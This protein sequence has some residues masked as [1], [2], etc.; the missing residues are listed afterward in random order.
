MMQARDARLRLT[1]LAVVGSALL[2]LPLPSAAGIVPGDANCDGEIDADDVTAVVAAIFEGTSCPGADANEDG[3]TTAADLTAVIR[4]F[5]N[6]A[7]TPTPTR[8]PT[9]AAGDADCN[10]RIDTADLDAAAAAVFEGTTCAGADANGDG[11]F[12]A[13]D[14]TTIAALLPDPAPTPTSTVAKTAT[15]TPQPPGT[16]TA[17]S[18][19]TQT[20]IMTPGVPSPTS[21]RTPLPS[22][23]PE[24][25]LPR[26]FTPTWTI[27][28]TRTRTP[29]GVSTG[30]RTPL[31]TATPTNT[32][33]VSPAR[34]AT[35]TPS[36]AATP[37]PTPSRTSPAGTATVTATPTQTGTPTPTFEG[38][39]PLLRFLGLV[40]ANG[41]VVCDDPQ[42]VCGTTPSPTPFFD[43]GG[44][45]IYEVGIDSGFLLVVEAQP[46]A[47]GEPVGDF[48]PPPIPGWPQRPDLQIQS[49]R[50]LGDGSTAICDVE[51][52]SDGG[53]PGIDPPNFDPA[54]GV[55]DALTDFACRFEALSP[56]NPCTLNSNGSPATV[57]PSLPVNSKQ[58]CYIVAT[59]ASFPPG[60][61]ILSV[62][63]RDEAG[64]VGNIGQIVVRVLP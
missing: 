11:L 56:G 54:A 35:R 43:D 14:L 64:N 36:V 21:T 3:R 39:G 33:V 10:G 18:T 26:T 45:R 6:V 4:L 61:T 13:A 5:G 55:N 47:S 40:R 25:T 2:W 53:V 41:C 17:T 58:F 19:R 16:P 63:V 29:T 60:E 38:E 28:A 42:C 1:F 46:G 52:P 23:T 34:T 12:T 48:V 44:R 20:Q 8:T 32:P 27:P 57:S 24:G 62:R 15:A 9:P 31:R 59:S 30:T 50:N 7:P 51:P 22:A 49:D 37:T